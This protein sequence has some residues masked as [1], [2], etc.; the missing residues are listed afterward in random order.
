MASDNALPQTP[1]FESAS[2]SCRNLAARSSVLTGAEADTQRYLL[3]RGWACA[4]RLDAAG[5][6][7]LLDLY[8]PGDIIGLAPLP[9]PDD[10]VFALTDISLRPVIVA[11]ERDVEELL[12]KALHRL[13]RQ[14]VRAT[15]SCEERLVDFLLDVHE[16]LMAAGYADEQ[17]FDLPLTQGELSA[18]L[19]MSSV[20]LNR[21]IARCN[22]HGRLRMSHGHVSMTTNRVT[23]SEP[24]PDLSTIQ[25]A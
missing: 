3:V 12:Y 24:R 15:S 19:G 11:S 7:L 22:A 16:R 17:G 21:T 9:L 8:L 2:Q 13:M 6:T 5:R 1:P 4:Q 25:S 10:E 23:K 18:L 14:G 20:H